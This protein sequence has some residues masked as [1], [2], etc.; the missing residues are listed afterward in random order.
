[1]I[2]VGLMSGTSLDGIDAAAVRIVAGSRRL[3]ARVASPPARVP[4]GP[5]LEA[6]VRAA[7]PPASRRRAPSRNSTP[8]SGVRSDAPRRRG[9]ER[10]RSTTS[11]VTGSRC[12]TTEAA[13]RPCKSAIRSRS[14]SAPARPSSAI[15]GAPTARPA[16][17]GAPLVPYVD[18]LLFAHPERYRVALNLGGIANVTLL[19]R[20]APRRPACVAWDTGPANMLLDAFRA[21]PHERARAVRSRR[22][23]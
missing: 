23:A 7:L 14:A 9:G 16:D 19:A 15:S 6:R 12:I 20:R 11:R 2:A 8:H 1:M 17:S 5:D 10:R 18:A 22:R 21:A 13:A 4:F 3:H